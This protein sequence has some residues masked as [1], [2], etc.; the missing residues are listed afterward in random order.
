MS[1]DWRLN[2]RVEGPTRTK[3]FVALT[4]DVLSVLSVVAVAAAVVA[5]KPSDQQHSLMLTRM[6]NLAIQFLVLW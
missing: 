5:V 1:R 4:I 3:S 2:G 6:H